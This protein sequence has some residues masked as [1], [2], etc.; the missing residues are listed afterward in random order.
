MTK[1]VINLLGLTP[2]YVLRHS[3]C[4]PHYD[5]I[6]DVENYHIHIAVAID[7]NW[8]YISIENKWTKELIVKVI[9]YNT[10]LFIEHIRLIE[11]ELDIKLIKED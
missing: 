7:S 10:N 6:K 5:I 4:T 3:K 8:H 1:D 11:K 2:T 9:C